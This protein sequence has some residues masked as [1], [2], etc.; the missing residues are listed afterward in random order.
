MDDYVNKHITR[1]LI[2]NMYN[3]KNRRNTLIYRLSES[4]SLRNFRKIILL[5]SY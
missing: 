1:D 5:S 4:G 3:W 2:S